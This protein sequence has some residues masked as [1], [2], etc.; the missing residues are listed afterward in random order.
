[1]TKS[2]LVDQVADRAGLTKQDATRA[3]D[4]VLSTISDTLRRGSEVSV[5]GFG[6]FH[7]SQRGARSGVN[8]R[9]G[10]RIQIAASRVP[11]F[12]AG[13]ALKSAVKGR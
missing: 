4:A 10:E 5:S 9:T 11:R 13:S 12:T 6:K 2:E 8:P 3:V 7:V 1:M